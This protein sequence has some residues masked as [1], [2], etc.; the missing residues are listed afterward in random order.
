M[1]TTRLSTRVRVVAIA[2]S[3][4]ATIT[5]AS[6]PAHAAGAPGL[7]SDEHMFAMDCL[8][9]PPKLWAVDVANASATTNNSSSQSDTSCAITAQ[10]DP[11]NGTPYVIYLD[12]LT[13]YLG[14]V[15]TSTGVISQHVALSGDATQPEYLII[16]NSGDAFI[17]AAGSWYSLDLVTGVTALV[18]SSGAWLMWVS[19]NPTND[20]LYGFQQTSGDTAAAYTVDRL[21][22]TTTPDPAHNF[23]APPGT[24]GCPSFPFSIYSWTGAAFDG[25]GNLWFIND[26]CASTLLVEDFATGTSYVP[27]VLR[28]ADQ[29]H[30]IAPDYYVRPLAIFIAGDARYND[31][32]LPNTGIDPTGYLGTGVFGSMSLLAGAA[33]VVVALSTGARRRR[34]DAF[35][36]Q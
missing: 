16:T 22:G 3:V 11:R 25:A 14:T 5:V 28:D 7:P 31:S 20:T 13:L 12:N 4:I 21:T 1:N 26:E 35:S 29:A 2:L 19:Y 9:A 15:D 24:D 23:V 10:V 30:G 34:R 33:L 36:R 32:A 8:E 18:G 17:A 27:G 6:S